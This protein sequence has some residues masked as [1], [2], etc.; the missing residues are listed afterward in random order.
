[1]IKFTE[2]LK[3]I[4]Y[5]H[6]DVY[7]FKIFIEVSERTFNQLNCNSILKEGKWIS[8]KFKDYIYRADPADPAQ[9]QKRHITI[10]HEKHKRA[11]NKQVSWNDTGK[12]HDNLSFNKNFIGFEKAKKIA[13]KVLKLPDN[14]IL[15]Q[16]L[17]T[18]CLLLE[19]R[20]PIHKIYLKEK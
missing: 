13:R 12:R 4:F 7:N 11:R 10:A 18:K 3:E 9:N 8:A 5:I 2:L 1:M 19:N 16:I 6:E 15:E 17:N 20:D 14:V